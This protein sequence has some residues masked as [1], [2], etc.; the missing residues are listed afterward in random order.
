MKNGA[1]HDKVGVLHRLLPIEFH[2]SQAELIFRD[3]HS[4]VPGL[5]SIFRDGMGSF[6]LLCD[7]ARILHLKCLRSIYFILDTNGLTKIKL[8][9]QNMSLDRVNSTYLNRLN[10]QYTQ[11]WHASVSSSSRQ[12]L[13]ELKT[14]DYNISKYLLDIRDPLI[15]KT[16]TRLRIDLNVLKE[17][18][19]R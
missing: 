6:K 13:S 5:I 14:E 3:C 17:C 16:F 7:F 18:N 15:R 12:V 8:N 19:S 11:N 2:G 9:C 4:L 10:N 1:P